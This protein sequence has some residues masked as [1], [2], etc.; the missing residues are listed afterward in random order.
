M[1]LDVLR[2]ARLQQPDQRL[3]ARAG[4]GR[5]AGGRAHE[6]SQRAWLGSGLG[7]GFRVRVRVR[8]RGSGFGARVKGQGEG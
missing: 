1:R 7:L 4:E 3:H 2:R 6:M 8:V 5:A